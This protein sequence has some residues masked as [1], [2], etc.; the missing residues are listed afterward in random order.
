MDNVRDLGKKLRGG[1]R[2]S[3]QNI[4][5]FSENY[6]MLERTVD[7]VG[8]ANPYSANFQTSDHPHTVMLDFKVEP[9][10]TE[11]V[12]E[13]IEQIALCQ[14]RCTQYPFG[15]LTS[16]GGYYPGTEVNMEANIGGFQL[17]PD[18]GV[19]V[20]F[21]GIY[22]VHYTNN[23]VGV[24]LA[25]TCVTAS[26]RHNDGIVAEQVKCNSCGL[27]FFSVAFSMSATIVCAAGDN[28]SSWQQ[29][30]PDLFHYTP[31]NFCWLEDTLGA[32]GYLRIE[33]VAAA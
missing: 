23:V 17:D 26:I 21:A 30:L 31:S 10:N 29:A 24:A 33:L 1:F 25:P 11:C 7:K 8:P 28:I 9:Y 12:V 19:I 18:H 22:Q 14:T 16:D 15:N 6:P 4:R 20:P 5:R 2:E 3:D 13:P 27:C 32:R